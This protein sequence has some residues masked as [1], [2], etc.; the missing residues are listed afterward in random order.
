[1]AKVYG[2]RALIFAKFD[3]ENKF[4]EAIGWSRQRLYRVTNGYHEPDVMEIKLFADAL[5]VPFMTVADIFLNQ[6]SP[7]EQQEGG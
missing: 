6:E 5:G 1:M 7:N 2:L 3:S 4:A